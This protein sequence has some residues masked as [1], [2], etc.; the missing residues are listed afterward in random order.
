MD[1]DPGP[2]LDQGELLRYLAEAPLYPTALLPG[3]GVEWTPIDDRSARATLTDR[4]TTASLVF[5]FNDRNEVARVRGTRG[6]LAEDGTYESRIWTGY[7]HHYEDRGGRR[8]PTQGEVS[9]IHPEGEVSYWRGHI[10][11]FEYTMSGHADQPATATER[12]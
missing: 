6:Y 10:F 5:S 7:W 3:M 4:G 12:T 11:H 2:M 9:W 8:V 1:A